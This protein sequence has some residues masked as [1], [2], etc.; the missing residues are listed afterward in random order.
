MLLVE[1]NIWSCSR[2][3][4][5]LYFSSYKGLSSYTVYP[6]FWVVFP[7]PKVEGIWD[8]SALRIFKGHEKNVTFASKKP[9]NIN[10]PLH[11][12]RVEIVLAWVAA[13]FF[14]LCELDTVVR[15]RWR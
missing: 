14:K 3:G 5:H 11:G 10:I 2:L 8:A 9:L 4:A 13:L 6:H 1:C 7:M 15:A 12:P